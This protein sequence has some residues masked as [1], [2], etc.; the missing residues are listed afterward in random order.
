MILHIDHHSG[1]PAYRQLIEQIQ[2][3]I[4]TGHLRPG[5][6]MP[7]TR[8]LSAEINLNPMTISKAYSQLERDGVLKR[9]RGKPLMVSTR[10]E[11][12]LPKTVE[13]S[14]RD[15][16]REAAALTVQLGL[17]EQHAVR[18][19]KNLIQESQPNE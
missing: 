8:S 17:S 7:S 14:M 19:F 9:Q 4:A 3:Q 10:S 11:T 12:V 5:D 13:Q 6:S 15:S 18:I 2:L 1:V 16:L